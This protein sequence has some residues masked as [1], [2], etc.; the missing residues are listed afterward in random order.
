MEALFTAYRHHRR[1]WTLPHIARVYAHEDVKAG[2]RRYLS[3]PRHNLGEPWPIGGRSRSTYGHGTTLR[4]IEC[5]K[6]CGL[7][8]VGY[9]DEVSSYIDHK[10]WFTD[11]EF[12]D[13]TLR[14][15][16]YALPHRRGYL[17]GYADPDNVVAAALEFSII[18]DESDAARR[19]DGI[20][21]IAAEAERD[22][23]DAESRLRRAREDMHNARDDVV[24]AIEEV[25][26]LREAGHV[27]P[28]EYQ[29]ATEALEEAREEYEAK[30]DAALDALRDARSY[31]ISWGDC[32]P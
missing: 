22:Y 15:V 7:R 23:R 5:P 28:R 17:A 6:E 30:R 1:N 12:Q 13:E 2:R 26:Q 8:L 20:A 4:W 29:A 11:S 3:N 19:A 31:G 24:G 9:A 14:G 18:E 32:A 27:N 16:V 10:G 25:R 21:E